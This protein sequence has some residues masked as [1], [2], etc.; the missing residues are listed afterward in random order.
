MMLDINVGDVTAAYEGPI[1]IIWEMLMGEQI[2]VG[3][4]R[5]T[6]ILAEKADVRAETRVLDVLSGLG[7]PARHLARTYGAT[8]LGLDATQRMVDEASRRTAAEGLGDRVTFRLGNALDMP[9]R[10]GIFDIVWGQDSWCYVT[11]KDRL[12]R[13]CSR[14]AAP[15]G[16]IA[17]TD[18]VQTGP[19]S[20]VEWRS[21]NTFMLFPSMETLD[22]Y[23]RLLRR[24]GFAVREREDLSD[25]FA[26]HMHRYREALTGDLKDSIVERFGTDVYRDAERGIGLWVSAADAGI[27]GRGRVIG[28][29]D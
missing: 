16:T 3:G 12:I 24:H 18:W 11:D 13:E 29:K 10:S 19:M 1:G 9:F 14:V 28:R 21:L 4:E 22:G 7:G 5:E 26:S 2:H 20:D 25:D 23:E 8:V 6:D 27:V 15:G 17:F